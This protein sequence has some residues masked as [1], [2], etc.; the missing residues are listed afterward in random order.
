MANSV[1]NYSLHNKSTRMGNNRIRRDYSNMTTVADAEAGNLLSLGEL[2]M[3]RSKSCPK[4]NEDQSS[5]F[6]KLTKEVEELMA[7][8]SARMKKEK[9]RRDSVFA[10]AHRRLMKLTKATHQDSR[11]NMLKV[12][13]CYTHCLFKLIQHFNSI[14]LNI[15]I[16][17]ELELRNF[18][19]NYFKGDFSFTSLVVH[20]F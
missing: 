10:L 6:S 4:M 5:D 12:T 20:I 3:S 1:S 14:L 7:Q 9:G 17:W 16:F 11:E 2:N 19:M 8:E 15:Q 18:I 13:Y